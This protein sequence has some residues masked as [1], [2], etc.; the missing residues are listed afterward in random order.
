M[1]S[2]NP[3]EFSP[4]QALEPFCSHVLVIGGGASGVGEA[5]VAD[6][7]V[8]VGGPVVATGLSAEAAAR[9]KAQFAR[10]AELAGPVLT[11]HVDAHD[12][13]APV[14]RP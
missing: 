9:V 14:Y 11:Y 1:T 6:G 4:P 2:L 12:E 7:R 5:D 10:I 8:V 3:A 13:P